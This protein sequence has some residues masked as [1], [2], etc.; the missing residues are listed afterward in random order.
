MRIAVLGTGT[1]G[2]TIG[3]KLLSLGH[4]VTLGSRTADHEKG[5]AWADAHG[6]H[7]A[8]ATF[9]DAT[10]DADLVFNCTA[11]VG[12]LEALQAAGA[13][14]LRGKV[15]LDIS[16]PLDFSQGFPPSL[17]IANTDSL[18]EAIQRAFPDTL[19]VKTLNTMACP[20]M[21]DPSRV[22]GDH[23]VFV[24]GNDAGAKTQVT[25]ILTEWFGWKKNLIIDL[26]DIT[27]ARGT[28]QWLPLWV[29]LYGTL[30][31]GDFNL[32]VVRA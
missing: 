10:R 30:G 18:G 32:H 2:Q 1:V 24:S 31:T 23:N 15:L 3:E 5:K 19:V 17:S 28:E 20:V 13:D 8:L 29:R 4:H 7:A 12:S 14:N 25:Q 22:P 26:G 6:D 16:N 21:V 11:G 9:Q 27:T